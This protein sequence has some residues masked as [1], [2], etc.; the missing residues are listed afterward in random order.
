MA[1]AT[2]IGSRLK[3]FRSFGAALV[4]VVFVVGIAAS[5]RA[6]VDLYIAPQF[7]ISALEA[8]AQGFA[9][10]GNPVPLR[11]QDHDASPLIGGAIGLQLPMNEIVPREWLE[12]IRLPNWPVRFE[13]EASG[14]R[15]FDFRTVGSGTSASDFFTEVSATTLVAN[16]WLDIPLA[17]MWRPA[18]FVFGLGR[19]PRVRQWLEPGSFYFGSGIG[20]ASIEIRATDNVFSGDREFI[21]FAWNVGAGIKYSLTDRVSVSAGYRY[22]G[23]GAGAGSVDRNLQMLPNETIVG[24]AKFDL[25][26][27]EFRVGIQID[28]ISFRGG[29]R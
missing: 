16:A 26:V 15:D 17:T 24:E 19:Q 22:L 18:Q 2:K 28:L 10:I 12:D 9:I 20:F 23:L 13:L 21:D 11:G 5:A 1:S 25:Q 29:W 27:H 3:P 6:D 8:E 4:A 14:L 7:G